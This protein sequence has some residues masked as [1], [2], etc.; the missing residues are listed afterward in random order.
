M[1]KNKNIVRMVNMD[2]MRFNRAAADN[3]V[4]ESDALE[5]IADALNDRLQA[6][7]KNIMSFEGMSGDVE[8]GQTIEMPRKSVLADYAP[9]YATGV[10]FLNSAP[11][12][13]VPIYWDPAQVNVELRGEYVAT[14]SYGMGYYSEKE[15]YPS[16]TFKVK[17]FGLTSLENWYANG[18]IL[19]NLAYT[20]DKTMEVLTEYEITNMT[21]AL[22]GDKV[23]ESV[24][25]LK[26][27]ADATSLEN[28]FS[29]C[30]ALTSV[31]GFGED[32]EFENV[33]AA[34]KGCTNLTS[35][36]TFKATSTAERVFMNCSKVVDL[37]SVTLDTTEAKQACASCVKLTT[38]PVLTEKI[39][40]YTSVF[41]GCTSL[42]TV[43]MPA[44]A[45]NYVSAFSGC[46]ALTSAP[47]INA[48]AATYA[49][50]NCKA[51][52]TADGVTC[53]GGDAKQM[54]KGCTALT[55]VSNTAL[56]STDA[57]KAFE[58]CS[59]LRTVNS[60]NCTGSTMTSAFTGCSTLATVSGLTCTNAN[61]TSA[62]AGCEALASV[63]LSATA[64]AN[65]TDAFNGCT[66]L[67]TVTGKLQASNYTRAFAGCT[68]LPTTFPL[69]V[70]ISTDPSIVEMFAGSSVETV[71]LYSLYGVS[72]T[73]FPE[74]LGVQ[75]IIVVDENGVELR[76]IDNEHHMRAV[77]W[78]YNIGGEYN[79]LMP[80][81]VNAAQV[82]AVTGFTGVGDNGNGDRIPAAQLHTSSFGP[83]LTSNPAPVVVAEGSDAMFE[84]S[85][86]GS[87]PGYTALFYSVYD[88][89]QPGYSN[90]DLRSS[91]V[92]AYYLYST[93]SVSRPCY[94]FLQV[95]DSMVSGRV[96]VNPGKTI[97]ITVGEGG[98]VNKI[99]TL[100]FLNSGAKSD[101]FVYAHWDDQVEANTVPNPTGDDVVNCVNSS[102]RM[103]NVF[104]SNY[105]TMTTLPKRLNTTR[106]GSGY[107]MFS[108]CA[109]L[110]AID[111]SEMYFGCIQNMDHMFSGCTALADIDLTPLQRAVPTN[112]QYMF[113]N[114]AALTEV[115]LDMNTSEAN[116]SYM[117]SGCTGLTKVKL[118]MQMSSSW[119][120][121]F[122]G[123]TSLQEIDLSDC[124]RMCKHAGAFASLTALTSVT[125][126]KGTTLLDASTANMFAGCTELTTIDGVLDCR[127][128]TTYTDMF[129]NC[130]KLT[131]VKLK[132]VPTGIT[133]ESGFAGLAAGQYEIIA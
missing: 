42:T 52:T 55:T 56:K 122:T 11:E 95:R 64:A 3:L 130:A 31:A 45:A 94:G 133:A 32:T 10:K 41:A 22:A 53:N 85:R 91:S 63:E 36:P 68:S 126:P 80:G 93:S 16:L 2:A 23:V 17:A 103:S 87:P 67:A 9:A 89:K 112:M 20:N 125:L 113:A 15:V 57:T 129:K 38:P 108:G 79:V 40:D 106:L 82:N 6:R 5:G 35:V 90:S 66:A 26:L 8:Q 120:N 119:T 77:N 33:T 100:S 49:F 124:V 43:T 78:T 13:Q 30:T 14:A 70:D 88:Y 109:A 44:T 21:G 24:P 62:F 123:C 18:A 92:S 27:T 61:F 99:N 59:K 25:T 102:Y 19:D 28:A 101:G 115:N 118:G 127:N 37:S 29:G 131:G 65:L 98:L 1:D 111:T 84:Y 74:Q 96:V 72:Q 110:T 128:V 121:M 117:F 86:W 51:M 107:Y 54:F 83:L 116:G 12:E 97:K 60:L 73:I 46:S 7:Y 75:T 114:C 58:S 76:V 104:A 39:T 34:F 81:F 71:K 69:V 47:A 48:T 4:I 105:T 132:N 50:Q